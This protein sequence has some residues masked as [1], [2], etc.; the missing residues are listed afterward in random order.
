MLPG[1]FVMAF[2]EKRRL[3]KQLRKAANRRR[4]DLAVRRQAIIAV[5]NEQ[6][7]S[8]FKTY[9]VNRKIALRSVEPI[10]FEDWE[11]YLTTRHCVSHL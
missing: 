11:G 8:C 6:I 10:F 4:E 2:K 3:V 1:A 7:Q 5:E 9:C